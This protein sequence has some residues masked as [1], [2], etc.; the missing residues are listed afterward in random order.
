MNPSLRICSFFIGCTLAAA[1]LAA[2]ETDFQRDVLPI[3]QEH[4]IDCHGTDLAESNLSL[5]SPLAALAGGDSGER[6]IVPGDA[7]GSYLI[8]RVT[9]ED[10]DSRMPPD[11][12]PLSDEQLA[13]LRAWVN[14]APA[15]QSAAEQL[16]DQTIDH[17]SFQPI[18]RPQVPTTVADDGV[19]DRNPIDA[20]VRAK[21]S[22]A[23]LD[24]SAAA[25]RRRLIRRLFL[26]MHGLPPTPHQV[27][28]FVDDQRPDAWELLVD[29]V[30]DS[31]RYGERWA[32]HWLD[33]VRFGETH[34]FETNRERPNAWPFRDWV[35]DSLNDDKPFDEFVVQQIAGDAVGEG[36]GTGFLVAGPY[37]LVKG[38]NL[39]LTLAQ[40]QDELADIINTTGTAFLGLTI[41]CARC[42]NH[43]FDP[44]SQTDYYAMQAVFAGVQHAE[45]TLPPA[46]QT[47]REL[48][49]LTQQIRERR[50]S[51]K[52][53]LRTAEDGL[54]AAVNAKRNVETFAPTRARF[55]R[56]TIHATNGGQ[57]CID[58]LEIYAGQRNVALA[59]A[60]AKATSSGDFTHP[61][62]KLAQINDGRYGNPQSWICSQVSGGWVQIELPDELDIHEV[63]WGRDRESQYN[64]RVATN[65]QIDVSL[66]GQLWQP[67]ASSQDRRSLGNDADDEPRY[68]FDTFPADV[69]QQ[70]RTLYAELE[71]LNRRRDTLS[72]PKKVYAGTFQQPGPTHRLYRGEP[73]AQREQVAPAA[74]QALSDLRLDADA[75][76]QQRRLAIARWIVDPN[77]PLTARVI[78]NRLWQ[79]HFGTGI[80]DT[81]SDFGANGTDP[82]HPQLLDWLASELVA[83]GWSLKRLHRSILLSD[84][85]R[86]DSRPRE[87]AMAVDAGSRLLWRF[88][89][90]RLEAEAI[91]DCM[92]SVTGKLDLRIGGPGFSAFEVEPENVRHYFPKSSYGPEDWRRMIYMTKVRQERDSVFG[93]FD[94]PDGSQVTPRRVSSTTPLQALNLLNSR[95]VMQQADFLVQR[96]N[97]SEA[98]RTEK[99]VRAYELC[100]ARQ[101]EPDE[102]ESASQFIEQVG[103]Q[104]FARAML[105]TNEFVFVP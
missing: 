12:D 104:A 85:W 11:G 61:L 32:A 17:W 59:T 14:N 99:I 57:P 46:P 67:V 56:F 89:P 29:E 77:N 13:H 88:P 40:R 37:D 43:K 31:P 55:V 7:A 98:S 47:T 102:V 68:A 38:K 10:E 78:V 9:T 103:W 33:L 34:G 73:G 41:G 44:I 94:C 72:E 20:F 19:S 101:P 53:F 95:F 21:L 69:A 48:E 65:Y 3:F 105:N 63:V 52:K 8:E 86:Q 15:W 1:C 26:V 92:L 80:V 35:I 97:A 2:A 6:V 62:H 45:R 84:T 93:V 28:A 74:L 83:G 50:Q 25:D 30:L 71:Q 90:R 79:G 54:R 23:G 58:E 16:A 24:M 75:P 42:H 51:L 22:D 70:G 96:L 4:C 66:D 36:V 82:T 27:Q 49:A 64:D 87:D 76:E 5:E 100:F 81:P 39:E 18:R 91:R 60:G